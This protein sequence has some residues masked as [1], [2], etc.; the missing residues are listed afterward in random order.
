VRST[1]G[2]VLPELTASTHAPTRPQHPRVRDGWLHRCPHGLL[3]RHASARAALHGS[4]KQRMTLMPTTLPAPLPRHLSGRQR[5]LV[6]AQIVVSWIALFG[7]SIEAILLT[8]LGVK[9]SG[10]CARL[11]RVGLLRPV[12]VPLSP[13]KAWALTPD[14]LRLAELALQRRVVYLSHPERLTLSMLSHELA[15][16]QEVAARL[17][18][19][20]PGLRRLRADRELRHWNHAAR[21]DLLIT[22]VDPQG[23]KTQVC[24][25]Y[26]VS[27]KGREE[28]T[29]KL[30]AILGLLGDEGRIASRRPPAEQEQVPRTRILWVWY[31]AEGETVVKRYAETWAAVIREH[32]AGFGLTEDQLAG[33]CHFE[34]ALHKP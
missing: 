6:K 2:L 21:P 22:H 24:L 16:Q 11:H 10:I 23:Q 9:A 34:P 3:H 19:D 14:G 13:V 18:T 1:E 17:P 25:E 29:A 32:G 31:L 7:H 15:L 26:E 12:P 33:A 4:L 8:V 28:L 5:G 27:S 20:L 30:L